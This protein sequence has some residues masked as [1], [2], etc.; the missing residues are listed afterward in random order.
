MAESGEK[1]TDDQSNTINTQSNTNKHT[2]KHD[3][4][5]NKNT[6][7]IKR[8]INSNPQH[9][10]LTHEKASNEWICV[11]CNY[12]NRNDY[13]CVQCETEL[14]SNDDI[15]TETESM[16]EIILILKA[17]NYIIFEELIIDNA[18]RKKIIEYMFKNNW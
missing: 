9:T 12:L 17:D 15:H 4:Q 6:N 14:I 1:Q 16:N 10:E 13:K 11:K 5:Q 18:S 3:N 7:D 8:E 2:S